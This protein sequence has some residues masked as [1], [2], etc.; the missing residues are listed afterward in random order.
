MRQTLGG[1]AMRWNRFVTPLTIG[2][3]TIAVASG[4]FMF[5]GVKTAPIHVIHEWL[6][7]LFVM[8]VALHLAD[9]K[10]ATLGYFKKPFA[11]AVIAA[12]IALGSA[13]YALVPQKSGGE[14]AKELVEKVANAPI[15]VSARL[16]GLSPEEAIK[17][18]A[19]N[20]VAVSSAD[21]SLGAIANKN[22]VRLDLVF[23]KLSR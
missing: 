12:T 23:E 20:G 18:L 3:G 19:E 5:F 10:K 2:F 21:G 1:I 11:V 14:G 6:G 15:A 22:G 8:I 17:R 4:A 13:L 9:H 16:F 7:M